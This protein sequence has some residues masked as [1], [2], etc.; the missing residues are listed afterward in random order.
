VSSIA[1]R[2][3]RSQHARPWAWLAIS[4]LL[5]ALAM[6]FVVRLRL[7]SDFQALLP[8]TAQSVLDLDEIRA[9][10]GGTATLTLAVQVTEGGSIEQARTFVREL[11]PRLEPRAD[12]Q[13]ASIDWN[14]DDFSRFVEAHRFLYADLDDLV[15]MRDSLSERLDYERARAN[16]FYVDLDDQPPPDPDA[17]IQRIEDDAAHAREEMDRFP[18]GFYQHPDEPTLLVFV[19]TG[20]RGGE[21]GATDRLIAAIEH[22]AQEVLHVAPTERRSAGGVGFVVPGLRIDYGGELMD[23]REETEALREAVQRSTIVTFVLLA[24]VIY[25]FFLRVRAF[26]LLALVLVPPVIVTFGIAEPIVH[27]L[28]ASTAFLGSIVVGNG[29]NSAVIWLGRYFEERREGHDVAEAVA[30]AHQNTWAATMA[31]AFA[32]GL[33][34]G[35]LVATEVRGFRDFG[36]IGGLGMVLCWIATYTVLP[37]LAIVSE[38]MRPLRFG[39]REKQAKGFYGVWS[40]RIALGAPRAVVGVAALL[41]VVAIAAMAQRFRSDYLEYDFR[42]LQARR[43]PASRVQHVSELVG[44]TVEETRSG[45]AL[46]ILAPRVE[47]TP[48]LQRALVEY[49]QAHPHLLGEVRTIADLLPADEEAKVPVLRELRQ[50][51]LDVR[52]HLS[53]RRQSQVDENLPPATI[54]RVTLADL[55]ESVA[56]PFTERDG[57]RG[58][59]VFVEHDATHDV[60]D[61]RYMIAWAGAARSVRTSDGHAPPIAGTATVFADLLTAIY[62]D[63]PIAIGISFSLVTLLI[64]F[65]FRSMRDRLRTF[66]ALMLGVLWMTGALA[67]I[68]ARLNF[69][70]L[71]AFPITFGIGV[72]YAVNVI[73]RLAEERVHGEEG[74]L[75]RSLEGAGGAVIL[76]S[77]TTIIGYISLFASTNRALNSF[78]LAMTISEITCLTTAVIVLPAFLSL[79]AERSKTTGLS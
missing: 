64:V 26:A 7:D 57:T 73:Q 9:R 55:P 25:L 21:A 5:A 74:A 78:G 12:L 23:V 6:P 65:S 52:P 15:E 4:F 61:G 36:V 11:V 34:Y 63:G 38:R 53:E 32:A 27:A 58:R 71:V 77:F 72:D 62:R 66:G 50:L 41:S 48:A 37:A 54:T 59:L 47:E 3:A 35:S 30:R 49:G 28:N 1:D 51:L 44:D 10:F 14:V 18:E 33:S 13:I 46:A 67:L 16:P 2:L 31:A 56:R 19:R 39:D 29:V 75:R 40:A 70:N 79:R 24:V 43:D 60:W 76:C 68:G 45:S 20:I 42:E 17:V 22:E 69:L 8:E